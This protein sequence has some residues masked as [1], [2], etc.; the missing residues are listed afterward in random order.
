MEVECLM[1]FCVQSA[2][3]YMYGLFG[4]EQYVECVCVLVCLGAFLV[5]ANPIYDIVDYVPWT[6]IMYMY[7]LGF[8]CLCVCFAG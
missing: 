5:L 2:H 8:P 3:G 7:M 6:V 4:R 1:V